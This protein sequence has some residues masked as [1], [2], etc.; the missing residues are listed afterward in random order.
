[1]E[2]LQTVAV[3]PGWA[4]ALR[5][6]VVAGSA[7][8]RRHR[9]IEAQLLHVEL[10]DEGIDYPDRVV[11]FDPVIQ[12]L[13]KQQALRPCLALNESAHRVP[14]QIPKTNSPPLT[15]QGVFTHSRP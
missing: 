7:S 10:V 9:S 14:L 12:T 15:F 5:T 2:A 3:S 8:V 4:S 13:R 11:L 1:M 6:G